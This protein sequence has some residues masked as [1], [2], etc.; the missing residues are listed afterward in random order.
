VDRYLVGLLLLFIRDADQQVANDPAALEVLRC[1][2]PEAAMQRARRVVDDAQPES[3]VRIV[4]KEHARVV[5]LQ[6]FDEIV[7]AAVF[8]DE[9]QLSAELDI[10]SADADE[11]DPGAVHEREN[12]LDVCGR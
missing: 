5:A 12:L 6:H 7:L 2:V 8:R 9:G 3:R 11:V 10:A 4:D 1:D